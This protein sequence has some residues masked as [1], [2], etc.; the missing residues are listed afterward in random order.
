MEFF[1]VWTAFIVMAVWFLMIRPQRRRMLEHQSLLASLTEGDEIVSAGGIYGRVAAVEDDAVRVEV[2]PGTVI[3]L[4]KGAVVR[5]L[6]DTAAAGPAP[7][8]A[9]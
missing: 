9:P 2:A 8:D 3:R 4:A 6:T 1:L 7:G 5:N